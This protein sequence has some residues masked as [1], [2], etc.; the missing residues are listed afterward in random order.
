MRAASNS[1]L[2]LIQAYKKRA[3]LLSVLGRYEEALLDVDRTMELAP[4]DTRLIAF[5]GGILWSMGRVE[6]ALAAM[7]RAIASEGI[8]PCR[9]LQQPRPDAERHRRV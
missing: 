7:D 5:R 1:I 8:A 2:R 3:S 4:D 6:D 9:I